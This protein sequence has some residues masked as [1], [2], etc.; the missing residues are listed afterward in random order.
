MSCTMQPVG[1][2]RQPIYPAAPPP[3]FWAWWPPS[4]RRTAS[5]ETSTTAHS[6]S[7]CCLQNRRNTT[8]R[9]GTS[10][11]STC[12]SA[13]ISWIEPLRV[14]P[15]PLEMMSVVLALAT[16]HGN[17]SDHRD[18]SMRLSTRSM[19]LVMATPASRVASLT[20]PAGL[21]PNTL[22]NARWYSSRLSVSKPPPS[23][24]GSQSGSSI[25]DSFASSSIAAS[26]SS[27]STVRSTPSAAPCMAPSRPPM[28]SGRRKAA[29]P[30]R[31]APIRSGMGCS[32]VAPRDEPS[33][34]PLVPTPSSRPEQPCSDTGLPEEM[35]RPRNLPA[36]AHTRSSSSLRRAFSMR[37]CCSSSDTSPSTAAPPQLVHMGL[38]I[39]SRIVMFSARSLSF[40]CRSSAFSC[41]SIWVFICVRR[42]WNQNLTWRLSRLRRLLSSI[43]CFSSG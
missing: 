24:L 38:R 39:A 27:R 13:C 22:A 34:K 20:Y 19:L 14:P 15:M 8:S 17:I 7:A 10:G 2:S 18:A 33:P 11:D 21:G 43:L 4:G 28:P 25:W 12:S 9:I 35:G 36:S 3:P 26:P 23:G 6:P 31:P 5:T 32:A 42:F 29:E 37:R 16:M 1:R 40:S 41:R 30:G